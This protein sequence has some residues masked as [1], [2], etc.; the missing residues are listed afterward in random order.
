MTLP[1]A[2]QLERSAEIVCQPLVL[3]ERALPGGFFHWRPRPLL[4]GADPRAGKTWS[5]KLE[6]IAIY[7]RFVGAVE[8]RDEQPTR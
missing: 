6:G 3:V 7:S 8:A 1:A 5:G 4:M 2:P